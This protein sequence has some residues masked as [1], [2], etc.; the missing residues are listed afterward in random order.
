MIDYKSAGLTEED[1]KMMYKWMDLGRKVDEI[2]ASNR[3]GK[4]PFVVSGQGQEATQMV[5]HTLWKKGIFL[6]H[7][8]VT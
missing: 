4:I 3:A 5:W 7:I 8:I 2:M 1:L 6:L